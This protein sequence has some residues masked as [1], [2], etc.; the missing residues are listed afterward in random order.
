[1]GQHVTVWYHN[2]SKSHFFYRFSL[3]RNLRVMSELRVCVVF[4]TQMR[5]VSGVMGVWLWWGS[6]LLLTLHFYL[7]PTCSN[8][9]SACSSTASFQVGLNVV[10]GIK[11]KKGLRNKTL[12][13]GLCGLAQ[14]WPKPKAQGLLVSGGQA[15]KAWS[16]V[17]CSYSNMV[18]LSD[19]CNLEKN[20]PRVELV[21][22]GFWWGLSHLNT[23]GRGG[24]EL[25]FVGIVS[26]L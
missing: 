2:I 24:G 13:W 21:L 20:Y 25:F 12:C 4:H 10:S 11:V 14:G 17:L 1:M 3:Y 9:I 26:S 5:V 18:P 23:S 22:E 19:K 7:L 8:M 16:K 6:S 15:N